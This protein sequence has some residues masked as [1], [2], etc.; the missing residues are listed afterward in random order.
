MV[1]DSTFFGRALFNGAYLVFGSVPALYFDSIIAVFCI[2][3]VVLGQCIVLP[4]SLDY[5]L[6][7]Q[8]FFLFGK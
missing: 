5:A 7:I 4:F 8:P 2:M 1:S 3:G 6:A